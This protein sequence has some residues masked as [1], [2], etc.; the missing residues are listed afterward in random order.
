V[1]TTLAESAYYRFVFWQSMVATPPKLRMRSEH[2][3]FSATYATKYGVQLH[4][5]P[6]DAHRAT[7]TDPGF[8]GTC[9]ALGSA[10]REAG[11][12]AVEYRSARDTLKRHCVALYTPQALG[13]RKPRLSEAWLCELTA[14]EVAFMAIGSEPVFRFELT[15]FL[16]DGALPHPAS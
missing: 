14:G 16:I 5:K 12:E 13:Q 8:Y 7:L 3:L 4:K 6:F 11:V 9:Q 1:E 10:M 15:Q 2:T